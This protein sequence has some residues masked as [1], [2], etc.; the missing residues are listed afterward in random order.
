MLTFS[1]IAMV[2][3]AFLMLGAAPTLAAGPGQSVPIH[4]AVLTEGPPPDMTAPG[5]ES[6]AIWRFNRTGAGQL[7][8]LGGVGSVQTHCTYLVTPMP[9]SADM[10]GGSITFTAANRDTLVLAYEG[11]TD[12][13]MDGGG[14]FVGYTAQGTWTIVSG[15]G[16]FAHA[17]GSGWLDVVGDVPGGDALFGLPDGFDRWSFGGRITYD[18]SDRS[19]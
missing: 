5:C 18:A 1:R 7:S 16:R 17:A 3:A 2:I 14:A 12:A 4:G 15:T 6:G 9:F 8:H 11:V 10:G 13:I 19:K